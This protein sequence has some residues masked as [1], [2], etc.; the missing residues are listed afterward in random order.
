[1]RDPF[2]RARLP[3]VASAA[4][5]L[6]AAVLIGLAAASGPSGASAGVKFGDAVPGIIKGSDL[7]R[8]KR[9]LH[10]DR[11]SVVA[12][13]WLGAADGREAIVIEP[14]SD[15]VLAKVK[16]TCEAG[17][18]CPDP[19]GFVASRVRVVL[20]QGRDVVEVMTAGVEVRGP[21]GRLFDL[22]EIGVEGQPLVWAG[23]AEAASGHV[24][25]VITPLVEKPGGRIGAGADPPFGLRWNEEAERFQLFD[26]VL[27]EEGETRCAFVDEVGE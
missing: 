5:L 9:I 16:E 1:M 18:Y 20:L 25:L 7:E 2:P 14:L 27:D 23:R 13:V 15:V 8:I 3:R 4:I 19:V 26:C 6:R 12:A 17:G 10:L 24:A 22:S 21:R 11:F